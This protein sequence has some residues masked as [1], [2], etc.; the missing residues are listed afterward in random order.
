VAQRITLYLVRVV[1]L[2]AYEWLKE[3]SSVSEPKEARRPD[4][5]RLRRHIER[6][7]KRH[8]GVMPVEVGIAWFGYLDAL[9]QWGLLDFDEFEALGTLL[10]ELPEQPVLEI[11]AL[12]ESDKDLDWPAEGDAEGGGVATP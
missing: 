6:S 3:E 11:M 4:P 12:P 10:P 5:A 1:E 8:G 7:N 2:I 9:L